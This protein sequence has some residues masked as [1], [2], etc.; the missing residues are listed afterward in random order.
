[1]IRVLYQ[2]SAARVGAEP[3]W[4]LNAPCLPSE[5]Y[6]PKPL[7]QPC[8]PETLSPLGAR[9]FEAL[10]SPP[11]K[12]FQTPELPPKATQ[13]AE[14][15]RPPS[16]PSER[17]CSISS[18]AARKRAEPACQSCSRGCSRSYVLLLFLGANSRLSSLGPMHTPESNWCSRLA[19]VLF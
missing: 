16:E 1:M 10:K 15:S 7:T 11:P 14:T 8:P 6:I 4:K 2:A 17:R 19:P 5:L 9:N 12:P 18:A 13:T 3:S